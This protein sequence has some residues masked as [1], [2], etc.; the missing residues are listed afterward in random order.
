ML[1]GPK[2]NSIAIPQVTTGKNGKKKLSAGL[3]SGVLS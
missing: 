2:G 1:F 3:K